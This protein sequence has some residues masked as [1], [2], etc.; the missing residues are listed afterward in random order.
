MTER[1]P[2]ELRAILAE[3]EKWLDDA[4]PAS[5]DWEDPVDL[6]RIGLAARSLNRADADLRDAV[7]AAR[8]AGRSWAD[9]GIV[10]GVSKQ[11]AQQRFGRPAPERLNEMTAE[12]S[13]ARLYDTDSSEYAGALKLA[14]SIEADRARR[15]ASDS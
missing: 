8:T 10:L 1:T 2:A 6:R 13:A 15:G 5:L 4:D 11:A 9:I 7:A 14:R 3:T 12:S